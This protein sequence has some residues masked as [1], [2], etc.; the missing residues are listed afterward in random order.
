MKISVVIPTYQRP[1][2]LHRLF[3]SLFNQIR[4]PEEVIV[5][6]GPSDLESKTVAKKWTVLLPTLKIFQAEKASVIHSLNLGLSKAQYEIIC[7]L[8]DDIWLPPDWSTKILIAFKHDGK[9]G[10]FGGRDHLQHGGHFW[11]DPPLAAKVGVFCWNGHKGNHHCGAQKSPIKVDVIKGVNLSFRRSAFSDMKIDTTLE[12]QGAETCWE[13]DI[14]Q[15]IIQAGFHNLYDNNNYVLH[16]W[17]PRLGFDNRT[18]VFSQAWPHRIFNESYILA[19]YRPL[20][21]LF[22]WAIRFFLK[23]TKVQPG[24]IWSILLVPKSG[25]KVL[26]LPWRNIKFIGEG[27]RCGFKMR[28]K[29]Q[30]QKSAQAEELDIN[31]HKKVM[32]SHPTGNEPARALI[33][34]LDK[35][36]LL[37]KFNTTLAANHIHQWIKLMPI[38]LRKELLRRT[39]PVQAQ[40]ICSHPGHELLRLIMDRLGFNQFIRNK[41][42]WI[43][44]DAIYQAFDK[45]VA[46]DLVRI[47]KENKASAVYSYEDGALMTFSRAKSLGLTCIY[48]LPI[49]YWKTSRELLNEEAERLPSWAK[50]LGG[51]YADSPEKLDRKTR[52]LEL[53]DIIVVPSEFVQASL[54]EWAKKKKIIMAHFGSPSSKAAKGSNKIDNRRKAN[55]PLRVLFAGSMS[56]RK[57]LGDLFEAMR[58]LN[59]SDVELVVMGSIQAPISFYKK[60][61]KNFIYKRVR[62]HEQVLALMRC[63]DILCLPSIVEGR[64]LVMQEAMSQGLP[65]IIT[66]NTGGAD[67]IKDGITGFLVP[68]RQPTAIAEKINWFVENRSHIAE[69]GKMAME[70]AS[71][72]TWN[73][74]GTKIL[75]SI[76][77]FL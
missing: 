1:N 63:C 32:F 64:A 36:N 47:V 54:P 37:A 4:K 46:K 5:V 62:P 59:Y 15:R 52:E 55:S 11:T 6:I 39:Y 24:I 71:L 23:G 57:G 44:I 66:P 18:D 42:S 68:I 40:Q 73:G 20:T 28:V 53:A 72:Y 22:V 30:S 13:I 76:N 65:I 75:H 16:Y 14:C 35:A 41:R 56:Q 2:D 51:G 60:N 58:M 33:K 9:L 17:S 49:A 26:L 38:G 43:S 27:G 10:A 8:D 77:D 48:D 69:M 31:C 7:L 70:H 21:E 19:K 29:I 34:S 45:T 67:L 3:E 61:F 74:Y 50:T 12:S 25:L